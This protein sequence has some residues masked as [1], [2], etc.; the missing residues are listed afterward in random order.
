MLLISVTLFLLWYVHLY[1]IQK[2]SCL[3][4]IIIFTTGHYQFRR[5]FIDSGVI[6]GYDVAE[7]VISH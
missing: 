6:L 7:K 4:L 1:F 2:V 3:L 5:I